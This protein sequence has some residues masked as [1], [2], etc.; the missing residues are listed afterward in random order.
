MSVYSRRRLRR[1]ALSSCHQNGL[2]M[3]VTHYSDACEFQFSREIR[4]YISGR[5]GYPSARI[6]T[7]YNITIVT[8]AVVPLLPRRRYV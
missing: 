2:N 8:T 1:K 5:L 7:V 4:W 6:C 3:T